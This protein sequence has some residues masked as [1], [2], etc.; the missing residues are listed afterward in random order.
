LSAGSEENNSQSTRA[1]SQEV[2]QGKIKEVEAESLDEEI[3]KKLINLYNLALSNEQKAQSFV[4]SLEIF[5][6]ARKNA[7]LEIKNLRSALQESEKVSSEEILKDLEKMT[8]EELTQ[9]Q[10]QEQE[11]L[12]DAEA[13]LL[14]LNSRLITQS[15]RPNSARERLIALKE[16]LYQI[17]I[18]PKLV[19]IEGESASITQAQSW[20][21][22]T[23][24]FALSSE[25]NM[26]DQELLS[27][28]E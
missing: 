6:Q 8:L 12:S 11:E 17:K 28:S 15:L 20:V 24:T 9:R 3:K 7:P 16:R 14:D 23:Q 27:Y 19:D 2:L 10:E 13:K 26:L 21:N 22:E 1:V 4:S 25:I 5:T 18:K